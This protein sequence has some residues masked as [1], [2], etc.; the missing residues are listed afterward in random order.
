MKSRHVPG[1]ILVWIC[2]AATGFPAKP[3]TYVQ[4]PSGQHQLFLDDFLV[5]ALYRV[6]RRVNPG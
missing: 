2:L 1:F 3:L 5:G 6:E 4:I